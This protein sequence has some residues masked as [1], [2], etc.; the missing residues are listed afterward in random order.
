MSEPYIAQMIMFGGN[1]A[2]R[3][4][5]FTHG[6]LLAISSNEALFSIVGTIYGGDGR[7]TF[8]LPDTRSR[9]VLNWGT[10]PGLSAYKIGQKTG[11]E[12]RAVTNSTMPSHTHTTAGVKA[13]SGAANAATPT[14]NYFAKAEHYNTAANTNMAGG[15][16]TVSNTGG[17][18]PVDVRMPTLAINYLISLVGLYP[19]RT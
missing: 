2:I 9:M 8:G 15:S 11:V 16:V 10:G 3:G 6:Q 14:N 7:T 13:N 5:A 4:W 18:Q 17:G 12:K 19:S 1:Y